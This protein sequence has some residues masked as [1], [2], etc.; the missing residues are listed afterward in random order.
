MSLRDRA[1]ALT[2]V[3]VGLAATA[4]VLSPLLTRADDSFPISTYP[5]FAR[6]R[7]Q[8]T[9]YAAVARAADGSERRLAPTLIGSAEVLQAKVLIA[10]SVEQG[11][12]ATQQLCQGIA[13]RIAATASSAELRG[14]EIVRRRYDPIAYFVSGPAPLEQ[15]ILQRCPV[16][17]A[18]RRARKR[19]ARAR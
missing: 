14:V 15:E 11:P 8:P 18:D 1:R 13:A 19:A 2:G 3:C 16:P 7:G 17:H 5:M 10:R 6:P 12:A 4:A 9:L